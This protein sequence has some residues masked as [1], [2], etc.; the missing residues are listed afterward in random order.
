MPEP[1]FNL[2]TNQARESIRRL[3]ALDPRVVWP[4]HA[5]PV[6]GDD[7][8]CSCSAPPQPRSESP[9]NGGLAH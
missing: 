5:K 8:S 2:D 7:V 6:S 4:A 9:C 3:A 1:A